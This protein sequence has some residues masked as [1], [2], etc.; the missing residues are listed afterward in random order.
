MAGE[1][2]GAAQTLA[3]GQGDRLG[4]AQC[5]QVGEVAIRAIR[6]AR[7]LNE[8]GVERG[9]C[10]DSAPRSGGRQAPVEIDGEIHI[11][12]HSMA[13]LGDDL[14]HFAKCMSRHHTRGRCGRTDL[15]RS[16]RSRCGLAGRI[17]ELL[18]ISA[19]EVAIHTHT[20]A[21]TAAEEVVDRGP[22][23]VSLDIPHRH[24]KR[25]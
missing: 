8:E 9:Q 24:F 22:E 11:R 20:V 2:V 13:N 6:Q 12:S 3:G 25:R 7:L 18:W 16:H 23:F 17:G 1:G 19:P 5:T 15:D 10:M 4:G 14:D 21:H